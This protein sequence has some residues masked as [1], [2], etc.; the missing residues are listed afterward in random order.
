MITKKTLEMKIILRYIK[1]I[2]NRFKIF[3]VFFSAKIF[4]VFKN[5]IILKKKTITVSNNCSNRLFFL[6]FE[7]VTIIS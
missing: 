7:I 2:K 5:I 1:N 6:L 3:Q 4:Q